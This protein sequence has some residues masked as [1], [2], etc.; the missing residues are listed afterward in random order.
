MANRLNAANVRDVNITEGFFAGVGKM[1][2]E[3]V[4]PYQWEALND[5]IEGAEPSH[6]VANFKIAAGELQGQHQGMVFQDSDLAKWIEAA[7][8]SLSAHPDPELENTIDEL[9]NT[10][11]KAQQPDGY[12]NTCFTIKEPD[13]RWTNLRDW[14]EM[15]CAG[16]MM[17]AAVAYFEATGKDKLLNVMRGMA[18]HI[19]TQFG[20]EDGKRK[21][22]PGHQ[23]IE[24]A[25]IKM[26]RATGDQ[27]L[28]KLA[29][30]FI[31]QRG[32]SPNYFTQEHKPQSPNP[33][34]K[35]P[36]S[37]YQSHLPVREQT[38]VEGHSVRALYMLSGMADVAAET[39][40]DSLL[41]A[42]ETLYENAVNRRM[43]VTGGVG[44]THIGEAFTYDYDL[45]NDTVYAETCA[46]IALI[47]FAHRMLQIRPDSRYAD[48][49]ERALY[50][51]C[52]A[53]MSL[54]GKRFFYVNPLMVS[55]EASEKDPAK[56]HVLPE[57]PK[58]FGCAC[59]PPNLAR[60]ITSIGKYIYSAGQSSVYAH[61]FI[62][63][64]AT[65]QISGQTISLK[66]KTDYPHNGRVTIDLS[67][68]KYR[69]MLRKPAWCEAYT[70]NLRGKPIEVETVDGYLAIERQWQEGDRV[71][72]D[73]EMPVYRVWANPKVAADIGKVCVMRGP[74]VYCAEE[75]DNGK[76][77]HALYLPRDAKWAESKLPDLPEGTITLSA[78]GKTADLSIDELYATTPPKLVNKQIQLIPYFAWANRGIGEMTV[79]LNDMA[80]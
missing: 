68:G 2:R 20:A 66:M 47:F 38:T 41:N 34:R 44:S 21:G 25:L 4:L 50:N 71:E 43:Y 1:V 73:M 76:G 12:L 3:Q 80:L 5:R 48:V 55:P 35:D 45:P 58:W 63:S 18:R 65:M 59:C 79:W 46:S 75:R 57:R 39:G 36:L 74:L 78:E 53:G 17:E 14:H 26:F 40:D 52:M 56:R 70:L 28:L 32:L 22:Y 62:D 11:A 31:N 7:A 24:L 33:T 49:I 54:D 15:Y 60:L 23:E 42:C 51:T 8:Y 19:M 67:A 9:V 37:Y 77:L 10:I 30:Y 72:Y 29:A 61:L 64:E 16:H 6:A 13:K 69:L 27:S